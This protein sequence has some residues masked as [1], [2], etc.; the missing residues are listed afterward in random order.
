MRRNARVII[1][2]AIAGWFLVAVTT[3]VPARSSLE[4]IEGTITSVERGILM[5][6]KKPAPY[7]HVIIRTGG[8][9]DT[10]RTYDLEAATRLSP[11]S[12]AQISFHA[13]GLFGSKEIWHMV[14]QHETVQSYDGTKAIRASGMRRMNFVL[15]IMWVLWVGTIWNNSD[16]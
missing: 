11:G 15:F 2:A 7:F 12:S 3:F 16:D 14:I 9:W 8:R 5:K 4:N 1:F 13:G 6:S 10:F